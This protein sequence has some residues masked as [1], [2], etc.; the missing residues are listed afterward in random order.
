VEPENEK[1]EKIASMHKRAIAK[2][3]MFCFNFSE[4]I[5]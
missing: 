4:E 1:F 2:N 3:R 5:I